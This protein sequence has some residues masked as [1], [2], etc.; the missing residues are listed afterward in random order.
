MLFTPLSE[1]QYL[2][3]EHKS[4]KPQVKKSYV[5]YNT[6]PNLQFIEL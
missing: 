6:T 1:Y 5:F 2:K 4:T 3:G